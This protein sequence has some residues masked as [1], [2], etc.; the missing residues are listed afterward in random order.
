MASYT[1]PALEE[2]LLKL[3]KLSR[4]V[5]LQNRKIRRQKRL[6]DEMGRR[7]VETLIEYFE[8]LPEDGVTVAETSAS[9]DDIAHDELKEQFKNKFHNK[10]GYRPSTPEIRRMVIQHGGRV[11]MFDSD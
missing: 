10:F 5:R 11:T 4:E 8:G 6:I 2:I 1:T 3:E 7:T 9:E